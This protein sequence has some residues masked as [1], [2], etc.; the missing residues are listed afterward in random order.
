ML[1]RSRRVFG[2]VKNEDVS[3]RCLCPDD[4]LIL[5]HVAG[6]I[7]LAV[8]IDLYVNL[9]LATHRP[10]PSVLCVRARVCVRVCVCV[11]V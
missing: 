3:R 7:D 2:V 11:C 1:T 6:T 5:W 10:K 9:Y 8:V 4:E